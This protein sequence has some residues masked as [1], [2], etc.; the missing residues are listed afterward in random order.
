MTDSIYPNDNNLLFGVLMLNSRGQPVQMDPTY[1]TLKFLEITYYRNGIELV[2]NATDLGTQ[3]WGNDFP[4]ISDMFRTY[5]LSG[6]LTCP[7]NK[8]YRVSGNYLS[9]IRRILNIRLYRWAGSP[10]WHTKAEI[11]AKMQDTL[12][13]VVIY[14]WYV[15]FDDYDSPIKAYF[16]DIYSYQLAPGFNKQLKLYIK[17]ND[18]EL[19][20]AFVQISN[21]KE[22]SFLSVD[23]FTLDLF[24]ESSSGEIFDVTVRLDP[25][26]DSYQRVVYSLLDVF[27]TV[28]GVFQVFQ[29]V[30]GVIIGIITTEAFLSSAFRRL[31]FTS[32]NC[33][34]SETNQGH[35]ISKRP[36]FQK[37]VEEIKEN[38]DRCDSIMSINS[39][40]DDSRQASDVNVKVQSRRD[41]FIN[42]EEDNTL[43]L[44]RL[45]GI[46][47]RRRKY[48]ALSYH[49]CLTLFSWMPM[50]KIWT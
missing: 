19:N 20:D 17:Q 36:S 29:T 4:V 45:K 26:K 3:D 15:D 18:V 27:G 23:R 2:G 22:M 21:S 32:N 37:R 9:A 14:N 50:Q 35:T 28:G 16:D 24:S 46:L 40:Y 47:S 33:S 25:Y 8:N 39:R 38:R 34:P 10:L 44:S 31:Y 6:A 13:N 11:D 7:L 48:L 30:F 5:N 43:L 42:S 1:F 41:S 49:K 12:F